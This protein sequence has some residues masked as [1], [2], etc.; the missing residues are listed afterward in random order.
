MEINLLE[1]TTMCC[2]GPFTRRKTKEDLPHDILAR[3]VAKSCILGALA[4]D[5]TDTVLNIAARMR[6]GKTKPLSRAVKK[7]HDEWRW[8]RH[9]VIDAGHL[10]KETEL[11]MLFEDINT[12]AFSRLCQGLR[13]EIGRDT[14]LSEDFT[15]LVCAVQMAMTVID[16]LKLYDARC[17]QWME[18]QGVPGLTVI[19]HHYGRLA[20]LLPEFAG[21]CYNPKSEA[22]RITAKILYNEIMRVELYEDND[23]KI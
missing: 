9:G 2:F 10:D 5:Y 7:L 21:D 19:P 23:K 12:K 6:I 20:L 22:R 1:P 17:G 13:L 18:S 4:W 15:M 11:A 8:F 14:Q 3:M 16:T